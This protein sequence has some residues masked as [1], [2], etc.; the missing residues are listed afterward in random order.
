[1]SNRSGRNMNSNIVLPKVFN[2]TKVMSL[3]EEYESLIVAAE[4]AITIDGESVELTDAAACQLFVSMLKYAKE[5]DKEIN[6]IKLSDKMQESLS[7]LGLDVFS[8]GFIG[9]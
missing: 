5:I 7:L 9:K 8:A 1:M 3:Q 2:I 4:D 6:I